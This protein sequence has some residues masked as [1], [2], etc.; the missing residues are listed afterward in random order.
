FGYRGNF[1][2]NLY[3]FTGAQLRT[4]GGFIAQTTL[5]GGSTITFSALKSC[6]SLMTDGL[7]VVACGTGGSGTFGTGNGMTVGDARYV[8]KSGDTMTGALTINLSSGTVGLRVLS[9]MSGNVLY[10]AKGATLANSG[11]TISATGQTVFNAQSRNVDFTIK[12]QGNA[13]MFTLDA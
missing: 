13:S 5:S 10:V 2:T 6:S 12:S 8:K 4:D 11:V 9:T 7:G 3:R 1:D